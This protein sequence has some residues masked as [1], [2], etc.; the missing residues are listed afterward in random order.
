[1]IE[2]SSRGFLDRIAETIFQRY[3]Q[4]KVDD[5][6]LFLPTYF[7]QLLKRLSK[8]VPKAHL[9]VSDFDRLISSVPG[10]YAPIVSFKGESSAEKKDFNTYLVDRG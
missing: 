1:M 10:K 9:I 3:Y 2:K 7:L 8:N 5:N 4:P 6:Q